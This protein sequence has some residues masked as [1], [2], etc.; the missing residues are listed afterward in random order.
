MQ[1]WQKETE[2]FNPFP[3]DKCYRLDQTDRVC[4]Q[5]FHVFFFLNGGKF[6]KQV[7][8]TVGKLFTTRPG[9]ENF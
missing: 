2:S 8:N 1:C 6:V 7:E 4:K 5:Q 9:E 3:N